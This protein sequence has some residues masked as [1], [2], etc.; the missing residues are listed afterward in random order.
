MWCQRKNWS[1]LA[2]KI[3]YK[4]SVSHDL[5][6]IDPKDVQRI[7]REI[8]STLGNNP[9]AGEAL[10]GEFRGLFKFRGGDF[11]IIYTVLDSDILILRVGHRSRVNR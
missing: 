9:Y 2:G 10:A 4:S 7:L 5:K 3:L 11:R 1:S 8:Q 6:K